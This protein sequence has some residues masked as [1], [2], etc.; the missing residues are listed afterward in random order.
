MNRRAH[1]ARLANRLAAEACAGDGEDTERSWDS[2]DV[3]SATS[4]R[5]S[6]DGGHEGLF[7]QLDLDRDDESVSRCAVD[8]R[9]ASPEAPSC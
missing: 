5:R 6:D 8:L 7:D 9:A 3:E 1:Q 4:T 2:D